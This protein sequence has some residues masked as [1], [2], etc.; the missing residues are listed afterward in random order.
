[1][2]NPT[3][4][5]SGIVLM[6]LTGIV[7]IVIGAVLT[8]QMRSN[9]EAAV[10]EPTEIG[11]PTDVPVTETVLPTEIPATETARSTATAMSTSTPSPSP[12]P[13]QT[14]IPTPTRIPIDVNS[15]VEKV[16]SSAE[17]TSAKALIHVE[18]R[19]SDGKNLLITEGKYTVRAGIDLKDI[20]KQNVIVTK[21][22]DFN[23]VTINLPPTKFLDEPAPK[24]GSEIISDKVALT[25]PEQWKQFLLGKTLSIPEIEK[26]G[27][28]RQKEAL[29]RACEFGLLEFAADHLRYELRQFLNDSDPL[30]RYNNYIIVSSAGACSTEQQ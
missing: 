26:M 12:V 29:R 6:L 21:N 15:V 22:G 28:D 9:D 4:K 5:L 27:P 3:S 7:G 8:S 1:M 25:L 16:K 19:Y 14:A 13:T 17:L 2:Q 30:N 18:I 24:P 23:D 20:T 10:I 11:M